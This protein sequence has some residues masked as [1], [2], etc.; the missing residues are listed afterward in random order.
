MGRVTAFG[1]AFWPFGPKEIFTSFLGGHS[2]VT[3][4]L[5]H[6]AAAGVFAPFRAAPVYA[7]LGSFLGAKKGVAAGG[8]W[9]NP[10]LWTL[11]WGPQSPPL[12]L[13]FVRF[14]LF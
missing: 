5:R 10:F 12:F 11:F 8:F 1:R 9:G 14:S 13:G 2:G 6:L 4:C 7:F 3:R